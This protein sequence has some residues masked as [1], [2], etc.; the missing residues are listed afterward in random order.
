MALLPSKRQDIDRSGASL[1]REM[2]RLFE[3][4][5]TG[6]LF[7]QPFRAIGEWR[8]AL[9]VA[10]TD[11]SVIVKADLPGLEVKDLDVSIRGDILTIR[12][13]KKEE[14]EEKTKSYHRV[15]R[16]YGSFERSVRL[17][18]TV[19]ADQVKASFKNGVLQIEMPKTEEAKEKT[20]RIKVD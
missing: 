7:V 11:A 19:K 6:D 1:Q 15:E 12:G 10:E 16:H 14:K 18:A 3:D 4:F 17:P 13:E 8:P 20:V 2:N 9:D 5:F